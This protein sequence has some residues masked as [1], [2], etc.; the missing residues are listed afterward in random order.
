MLAKIALASW[1]SSTAPRGAPDRPCSASIMR[2][3]SS[4]SCASGERSP[5]S[6]GARQRSKFRIGALLHDVGKL[7][8]P[9]EVLNKPGKLTDEVRSDKR[10][11][12]HEEAME[13]IRRDVGTQFDAALLPASEEVMQGQLPASTENRPQPTLIA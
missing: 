6:T 11:F 12:S 5:T 2:T 10:A 13:L 1:R 8:V 3:V 7:M 4:P 9:A